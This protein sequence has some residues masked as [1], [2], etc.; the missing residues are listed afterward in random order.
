MTE[1]LRVRLNEEHHA[2]A[3]AREL[4]DL[5]G[6]ELARQDGTWEVTVSGLVGDKLVVRVLNAVSRVLNGET[7]ATALVFL[8][9]REYQIQGG[10]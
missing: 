10:E 9:G 1:P 3:L 2:R 5:S 6:F 4:D 7:S 8:N